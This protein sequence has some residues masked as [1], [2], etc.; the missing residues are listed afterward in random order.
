MLFLLNVDNSVTPK[1]AQMVFGLEALEITRTRIAK[2]RTSFDELSESLKDLPIPLTPVR[3]FDI[4][5]WTTEK[6]DILGQLTAP[7]GTP[8][9]S[10]LHLQG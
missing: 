8:H 1:S 6:W 7:Y 4:L 5:C 10:L 9:K 3:I 2:Q